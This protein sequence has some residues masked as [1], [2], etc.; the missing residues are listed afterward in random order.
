M[1]EFS[2]LLEKVVLCSAE[3]LILGDFNLHVD[4]A[5][6][7]NVFKSASLLNTFDLQQQVNVS[8]H[9]LRHTLDLVITR[10][11]IECDFPNNLRIFEELIS[12]H[13]VI[14]FHLKLQKPI[15]TRKTIVFRRLKNLDFEKFNDI[16]SQ[17][18]L[19]HNNLDLNSL[20]ARCETVTLDALER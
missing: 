10:S 4:V 3:L 14:M 11:S 7:N 13:K 16:I 19:L 9:V 17:S 20:I 2:T 5:D 18:E 1:D 6:K 15:K 12:D 8:T